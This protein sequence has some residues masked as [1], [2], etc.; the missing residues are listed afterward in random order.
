MPKKEA[1]SAAQTKAFLLAGPLEATLEGVG[2]GVL[3]KQMKPGLK[4]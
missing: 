4:L 1:L 3:F 2:S